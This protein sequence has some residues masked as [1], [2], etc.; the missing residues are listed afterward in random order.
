MVSMGSPAGLQDVSLG[1]IG[2]ETGGRSTAHHIDNDTGHLCHT[3][4]TEIFLHEGKSG[5]TGGSH[6]FSPR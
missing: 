2:G 4:E 5:S 1:G 6:G 3:G